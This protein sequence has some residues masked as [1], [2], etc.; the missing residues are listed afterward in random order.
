MSDREHA[1]TKLRL[2][3]VE[4][5]LIGRGIEDH[6]VIHAMEEVPRHLF[7][8][9]ELHDQA[10]DDTPLPLGPEQTISQPLIVAQMIELLNLK[11][12]DRVL[13]IGTGSGYAAGVL[14]RVCAEVYTI[15]IDPLLHRWA[16][17]VLRRLNMSNVECR[18]GNG[19]LGW[20]EKSPF[21]GAMASAASPT[22]P[23]ELLNQ[24]K[25]GG[26]L[27]YPHGRESQVLVCIEK[28]PD[29]LLRT[30]H[31]GVRFVMLKQPE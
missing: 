22:L 14:S 1:F 18:L 2:Q 4:R 8:P 6:R 12:A 16:S 21:D 24:L 23:A 15:E 25:V 7:V 11:S 20:P 26:R 30:E 9:E 10:Y 28:T 19:Y 17:L 31:G 5:Q 13:E 27:V 29:G 3:M